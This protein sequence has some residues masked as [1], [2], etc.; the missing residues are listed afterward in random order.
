MVNEQCP[1]R[2]PGLNHA[3]AKSCAT[4]HV[5]HTPTQCCHCGLGSMDRENEPALRT[6]KDQDREVVALTTDEA[7]KLQ[8]LRTWAQRLPAEE[9]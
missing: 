5:D 2:Q 8:A 7:G 9:H 3:H 4:D 6:P 1:G